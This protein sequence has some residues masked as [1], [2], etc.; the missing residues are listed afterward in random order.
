V[1]YGK[2]SM[3]AIPTISPTKRTKRTCRIRQKI[4]ERQDKTM[5]GG[6]DKR[7]IIHYVGPRGQS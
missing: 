2:F 6:G 5:G 3:I 1:D 4:E 7:I